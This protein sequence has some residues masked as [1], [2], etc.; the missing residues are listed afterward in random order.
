[1][2]CFVGTKLTSYLWDEAQPKQICFSRPEMADF[3]GTGWCVFI[4]NESQEARRGLEARDVVCG[5]KHQ[6]GILHFLVLATFNRA[7]RSTK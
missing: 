3:A 5:S 6:I 7:S 1:M 4:L 2:A